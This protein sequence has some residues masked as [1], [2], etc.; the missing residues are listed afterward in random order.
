MRGVFLD[1][2]TYKPDD[3]HSALLIPALEDWTFYDGTAPEQVLERIAGADVVV[4]NK[5]RITPEILDQA[6]GLKLI[7]AGAT[8]VDNI[9]ID[10]AAARSIP[11]CNVRGYSTEAV[12]QLAFTLM[13]SL[14]TNLIPYHN[15]VQSGAWQKAQGF[16]L[17][18]FPLKE[19]H[20]KT[21]GIFGHGDIGRAVERIAL[22]FGMEILIAD[23]KGASDLRDGRAAF[24]EVIARA[25][26]VTVHC[27]LT[28]ET[29]GMIGA[30]ELAAMKS[31]ALLINVSRGGIVDEASLAEALRAGEIAGAGLDVLSKE[32]PRGGNA[33]LDESLPNL[34]ITPHCAWASEEARLRMFEQIAQIIQSFRDGELINQVN[35]F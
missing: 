20:G 11:V 23:R 30:A 7:V 31:S 29:R 1:L 13:L 34:I 3:R 18:N 35:A 21:L 27:P 5:V 25:D 6:G 26:I 24:E 19:L 28:D 22:A 33:L 15:L 17:L 4:T 9:D 32:P 12:A 2:E 10:A 14:S 8:G 16:N